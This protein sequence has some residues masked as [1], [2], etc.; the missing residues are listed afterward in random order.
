MQIFR[1]NSI[2]KGIAI[3]KVKII[4]R[5]KYNISRKRINK[6]EIETEL[7]KFEKH[8]EEVIDDIDDLIKKKEHTKESIDILDTHK[9]ILKDPDF[10]NNIKNLIQSDLLSL[11]KAIEEHFTQV[12][13]IFNRMNNSLFSSRSSDYRDVA[14]R[15]LGH[16][17]NQKK[18]DDKIDDIDIVFSETIN[19]SE[20][21]RF[22]TMN[23]KGFCVESGSKH[24]HSAIIARSMNIPMLTNF[25]NLLNSI[26]N[27]EIVILDGNEGLFIITPDEQTLDRYK[28]LLQEQIHYQNELTKIVDLKTQTLDKHIIKLMSNIE[29]PEEIDQVKKSKSEGIGLFRTEFLFIDRDT[30]PEEEEQFK[31][32]KKIAESMYPEPVIIRTIDAGGDKLSNILNPIMEINPN[33]G[34][35]GIRLSFAHKALFKIQIRAILR[36]NIGGNIKIMFPMISC[37]KEI[38]KAKAIIKQCREELVTENKEHCEY[39]KIGAMI[40]IPSA[41]LTSDIISK[42][43]DFLSIGTNDLTQYTLAVDRDN[44]MVD[45]YYCSIHP[46]VIQLIKTTIKNAHDNGILVAVCGEMASTNELIPLLIGLGIDELSVSPGKLLELKQIILDLSYKKSKSL[47]YQILKMDTIEQIKKKLKHV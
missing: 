19:P 33:L 7:I 38:R 42:E 11:E 37:V 45:K 22:F 15:L 32:Y 5:H 3:G 29:I 12:I 20:V 8:I 21:T 16:I 23:V 24:S 31:I 17:L 4:K 13:G 1:G 34:L 47:A 27:D 46:A 6:K 14:E 9:M 44:E 2:S 36:A 30:L 28:Q 26:K 39:I 10:S 41:A 25:P 18:N 40:E 35:R 43:C